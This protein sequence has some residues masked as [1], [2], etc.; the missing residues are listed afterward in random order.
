MSMD[1]RVKATTKTGKTIT[2]SRSQSY[3]S[4]IESLYLN[5]PEEC[6]V[7][8]VTVLLNQVPVTRKLSHHNAVFLRAAAKNALKLRRNSFQCES[9]SSDS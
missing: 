9:P 7:F 2:K 3:V 6:V 1:H 5:S 4:L 8:K